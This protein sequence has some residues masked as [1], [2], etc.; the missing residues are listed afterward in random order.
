[1]V[2]DIEY[3]CTT[4][5]KFIDLLNLSNQKN[6]LLADNAKE[7]AVQWD[8][9]TVIEFSEFDW[10]TLNKILFIQDE[11]SNNGE[12]EVTNTPTAIREFSVKTTYQKLSNNPDGEVKLSISKDRE[13]NGVTY[14][15][16][17]EFEINGIRPLIKTQEELIKISEQLE[18]AKYYIKEAYKSFDQLPE[19]NLEEPLSA[20]DKEEYHNIYLRTFAFR[21]VGILTLARIYDD[22]KNA[23]SFPNTLERIQ[24]N[25]DDWSKVSDNNLE[26]NALNTIPIE[27]D[28]KKLSK[29]SELPVKKLFTQRDKSI[30]HLDK[31]Y[32]FK[33]SKSSKVVPLGFPD[34]LELDKLIIFIDE[35]L[36]R[37]SKLINVS[38]NEF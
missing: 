28:R 36:E 2:Y 20:K 9:V 31:A 8:N 15:Y 17:C 19:N 26:D 32:V 29:D 3:K 7:F 16:V 6:E 21:E 27:Q 5:K 18:N 35:L 22:D 13:E 23:V 34:R 38:L 37:Y 30:A 11:V 25:F 12:E 1:M 33:F 10:K 14:Y 24:K 4:Q